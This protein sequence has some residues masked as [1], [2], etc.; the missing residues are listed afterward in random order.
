MNT[1]I[2]HL[3][4]KY[5]K[6]E[7]SLAEEVFLK[8]SLLC[9]ETLPDDL[10]S[11]LIFK[12]FSEERDALAPDAIK[13]LNKTMCNKK[14]SVTWIYVVTGIAACLAIAFSLFFHHYNKHDYSAYVII[15]GIRYNDETMAMEYINKVFE[16]EARIEK[17][18]LA[19][20]HEMNQIENELNDIENNIN[21]IINY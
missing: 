1:N 2:N 9:D 10:Y 18:A 21:N 7:A 11:S 5:Y 12:T 15:N 14:K 8:N 13:S 4:D 6:G 19:Q 17:M 20:L 3:I 16:E